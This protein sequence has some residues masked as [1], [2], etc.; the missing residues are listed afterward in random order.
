MQ[1]KTTT[2]VK[3]TRMHARGGAQPENDFWS[4]SEEDEMHSKGWKSSSRPH[5]G[6]SSNGT[7]PKTNF[8]S[9]SHSRV[10]SGSQSRGGSGN[11]SR[12]GSGNQSRGGS[13]NQ[14]RG[15]SGNQGR[16]RSG[17]QG[18]VGSGDQNRG[19]SG[20]KGREGYVIQSRG[21]IGNQGRGDADSQGREILDVAKPK[22]TMSAPKPSSISPE[23]KQFNP[24]LYTSDSPNR[25]H[26]A[27]IVSMSRKSVREI[28]KSDARLSQALSSEVSWFI[29]YKT[30][31][32]SLV[33]IKPLYIHTHTHTHTYTHTHTHI[34]IYDVSKHTEFLSH[35]LL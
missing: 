27:S 22:I 21:G 1:K 16:G 5:S 26:P 18:R 23:H 32:S 19:G 12:G 20:D 6:T 3:A 7:S 4:S 2:T 28:P 10:R 15:G 31:K 8:K 25:A 33:N 30:A 17:D 29:V 11:Q 24:A 9:G 35:N 34:S 13:G 14:S